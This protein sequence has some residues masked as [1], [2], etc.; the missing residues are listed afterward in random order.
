VLRFAWVGA[1]YV[2][3]CVSLVGELKVQPPHHV[4]LARE[5][6]GL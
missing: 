3:T 2:K 6:A 5:V 4:D 1:L